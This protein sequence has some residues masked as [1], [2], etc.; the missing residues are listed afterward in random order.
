LR[1]EDILADED[2]QYESGEDNI[3]MKTKEKPLGP[4]LELEI[5]LRRAPALPDKVRLV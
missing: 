3:D 2:H 4:P 5:P 1:P